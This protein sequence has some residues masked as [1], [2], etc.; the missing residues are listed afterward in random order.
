M[1]L[2]VARPAAS[3]PPKLG[4]G[5]LYNPSLA[6]LL[7]SDVL[8][9]DYLEIIPEMFWLDDEQQQ[10]A[11][12]ESWVEVLDTVG[13]KRPIV[14]HHTGLSL[15]SADTF[16]MWRLE[17]ITAW[18]ERYRFAWHSDHL[19]FIRTANGGHDHNAGLA[20]PIPYDWELLDLI[21][22]RVERIR[23]AVA[24]PFLIE[25]GAFFTN[26]AEQDMTEPEFLNR[27]TE[28]TGCGVILDLHNVYTNSRNHGFDPRQYIDELDLSRVWEIHIAGGSELAGMYTDSHA[29]PVAGP[30]WELLHAVVP[31]TRHLAGIT[32][33]FHDSYFPLMQA[34]GVQ[35]ELSKAARAWTA[36]H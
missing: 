23:S 33:E 25:N 13:A 14:A 4:V 11:E 15:G 35:E 22:E 6:R 10:Y 17:R 30:V 31:R 24:I 8:N 26:Y 3:V 34:E 29:G 28:R 7:S 12:L 2:E 5:V 1:S 9:V 32:F 20:I 18:H 36:G 21:T 16:E 19:S 27:L